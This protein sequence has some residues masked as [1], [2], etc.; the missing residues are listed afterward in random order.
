VGK[1]REGV[2]DL[3]SLVGGGGVSVVKNRII[4]GLTQYLTTY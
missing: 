1:K 3:L 2:I 4:T